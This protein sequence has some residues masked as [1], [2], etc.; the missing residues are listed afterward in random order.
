MSNE[1]NLGDVELLTE[2]VYMFRAKVIL[3]NKDRFG[4]D[5]VFNQGWATVKNDGSVICHIN[6]KVVKD[7]NTVKKLSRML[8][9]KDIYFDLKKI[10]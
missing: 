5:E 7:V 6:R 8:T 2:G 3:K 1:N 9:L 4:N 10:V